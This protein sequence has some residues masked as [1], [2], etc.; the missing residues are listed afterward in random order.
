[1]WLYSWVANFVVVLSLEG[2]PLLADCRTGM[3]SQ[4]YPDMTASLRAAMQ[5]SLWDIQT[6]IH[7]LPMLN[8]FYFS[9]IY[10]GLAQ[11]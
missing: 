9:S 8:T 7:I 2:E 10:P 11:N 6:V 3:L 4:I 5:I 1:M